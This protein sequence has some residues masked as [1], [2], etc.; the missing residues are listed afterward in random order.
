MHR[1]L[2]LLLLT[3]ACTPTLDNEPPATTDDD[4][5]TGDDDDDSTGDDDDSTPGDDDDD[6]TLGCDDIGAT[7]ALSSSVGVDLVGRWYEGE[8]SWTGD[9]I[10]VTDAAGVQ[11]TFWS[12][13]A[14][15][16]E[17][18]VGA[19]RVFWFS[20]GSTAWGTDNLLAVELYTPWYRHAHGNG[21]APPEELEA[22]WGLSVRPDLAG[23][24][25]PVQGECGPYLPLPA[26]VSTPDGF[27]GIFQNTLVPGTWVT[28]SKLV[29]FYWMGGRVIEEVIC[30]DVSP[31]EY[32]WLFTQVLDDPVIGAQ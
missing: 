12:S 32:A 20:G 27:G 10:M 26:L 30:P 14:A 22:G 3:V 18:Y 21:V 28:P 13:Q 15:F 6:G 29:G 24:G 9:G 11:T 25:D 8:L 16:L 4:D 5:A 1:L 19:G 2:L 31:L 17:P 23:C 7:I